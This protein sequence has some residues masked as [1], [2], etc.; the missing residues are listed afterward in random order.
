LVTLVVK[1][2]EGMAASIGLKLHAVIYVSQVLF[3]SS[4]AGRVVVHVPSWEEPFLSLKIAA[5]EM[6]S[7][8]CIGPKIIATVVGTKTVLIS[9]WLSGGTIS[10]AFLHDKHLIHSIGGI[11]GHF[12]ASSTSW[13]STTP[14]Q[15][16]PVSCC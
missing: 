7:D 2:R 14:F 3:V 10:S 16:V 5:S 9:E 13:F 1:K 4:S 12:H 15:V 6:A 8:S 11:Y